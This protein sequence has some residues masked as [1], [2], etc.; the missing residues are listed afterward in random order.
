MVLICAQALTGRDNSRT[1]VLFQWGRTLETSILLS[2]KNLIVR[3]KIFENH[4]TISKVKHFYPKI[5]ILF[6]LMISAYAPAQDICTQFTNTSEV[7]LHLRLGM[8]ARDVR[9]QFGGKLGIKTNKKGDYR[10]FQNFI[11]KDPPNNLSGVRAVYLRFFE[12]KLYQAEIFYEENKYPQD[13]RDFSVVVSDQL[14][15]P[16]AEWKIAHRQAV[17]N[18]GENSLK[19]D[20]QL[21]PRI[22]LTTETIRKEVDEINKKKKLF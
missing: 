9:D 4:Y 2:H 1:I 20:Y 18:C 17:F 7:L 15:L 12:S 10:F 16:V 13:I 14:K 21:N 19:I 5:A 8:T 22:E 6:L 3:G 11:K